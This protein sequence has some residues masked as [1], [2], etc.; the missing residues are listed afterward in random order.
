VHGQVEQLGKMVRDH[1]LWICFVARH[2]CVFKRLSF[3]GKCLCW[4]CVRFMRRF[5]ERRRESGFCVR[6]PDKCAGHSG[7]RG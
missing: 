3:T 5:V 2:V 6:A 1:D 7:R 4:K